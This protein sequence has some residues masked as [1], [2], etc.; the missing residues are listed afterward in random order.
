[1]SAGVCMRV[2]T[3]SFFRT[4]KN[5]TETLDEIDRRRVNIESALSHKC[6][7]ISVTNTS[8]KK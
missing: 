8:Q 7:T 3:D 6:P 5:K 2:F 4:H 1:M